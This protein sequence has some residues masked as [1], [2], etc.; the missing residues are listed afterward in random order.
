MPT[1]PVFGVPAAYLAVADEAYGR[2]IPFAFLERVADAFMEKFG[3]KGRTA[4]EGSLNA[5]FRCAA[6]SVWCGQPA[7][8]VSTA[9]QRQ[10]MIRQMQGGDMAGA[11]GMDAPGGALDACSRAL[12]QLAFSCRRVQRQHTHCS[13]ARHGWPA[14]VWHAGYM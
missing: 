5:S 11:A 3:E 1:A 6:A 2:Q 12:T 10:S 9:A 8:G 14:S 4:A 13:E 7:C